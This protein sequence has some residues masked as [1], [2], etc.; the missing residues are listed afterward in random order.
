MECGKNNNESHL[1]KLGKAY[2]FKSRNFRDRF[3][4]HFF[5]G[6]ASSK[7]SCDELM[8]ISSSFSSFDPVFRDVAFFTLGSF[9]CCA[10]RGFALWLSDP[11]ADEL[12]KMDASSVLSVME[13]Y[14]VKTD[15]LKHKRT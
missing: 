6:S 9:F 10:F 5:V 1:S 2:N 14:C 4:A 8:Q 3:G 7:E 13:K 11:V 12:V 15:G